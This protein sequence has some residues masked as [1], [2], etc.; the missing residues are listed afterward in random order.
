MEVKTSIES[1]VYILWYRLSTGI[2]PKI[3]TGKATLLLLFCKLIVL[4][5]INLDMEAICVIRFG[6]V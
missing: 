5:L 2:A 1:I 6:L 3:K 4:T